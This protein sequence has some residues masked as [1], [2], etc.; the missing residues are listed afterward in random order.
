LRINEAETLPEGIKALNFGIYEPYGVE[1]IGS[2]CY[3]LHDDD[4]ACEE[5]FVPEERSCPLD[6]TMLSLLPHP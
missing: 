4:W 6:K 1:V 3:D 5:D 2:F